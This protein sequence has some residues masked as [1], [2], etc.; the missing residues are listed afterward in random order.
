MKSTT[1]YTILSF[2]LL[3]FGL[4]MLFTS[5]PM[6]LASFISPT[7]LFP[8]FMIICIIIYIIT[9]FIFLQKGIKQEIACK[10]SLKDWIKVNAFVTIVFIGLMF[11]QTTIIIKNPSIISQQLIADV[12][13]QQSNLPAQFTPELIHKLLK[14]IG[15][16]MLIY[17]IILGIHII[18]TFRLIKTYQHIFSKD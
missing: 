7:A 17:S 5:L 3:P 1:L 15:Y 11:A 9:C 10:R 16:F 2:L 18:I 13:A 8:L 12:S 4:I 6:L 14:F